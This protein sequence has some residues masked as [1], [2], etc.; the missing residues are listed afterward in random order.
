MLRAANPLV[1]SGAIIDTAANVT[2]ISET[3]KINSVLIGTILDSDNE[4]TYT[5]LFGYHENEP[6]F[7]V[8]TDGTAFLGKIGRGRINFDG[9]GGTI[10]SNAYEENP[11]NGTIID[12]TNSSIDLKGNVEEDG[13]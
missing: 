5:G 12:L 11:H 1:A 7:A 8:K 10:T 3:G 2:N 9:N 13:S 6:V 4:T